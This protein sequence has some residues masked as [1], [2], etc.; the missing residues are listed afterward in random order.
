MNESTRWRSLGGRRRVPVACQ[1]DG[2][3]PLPEGWDHLVVTATGGR[4]DLRAGRPCQPPW[5]RRVGAGGFA[6]VGFSRWR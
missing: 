3:T 4:D 1:P 2:T 5:R 6:S